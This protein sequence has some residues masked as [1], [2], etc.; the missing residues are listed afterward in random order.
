MLLGAS[1]SDHYFVDERNY[2]LGSGFSEKMGVSATFK[3]KFSVSWQQEGF[4]IFTT[5]GYPQD[6]DF[7]GT[8]NKGIDYQGDK[9]N[10]MLNTST[11]KLDVKLYKQLYFSSE[12]SVFSRYTNYKYFKDVHSITFEKQILLTYKF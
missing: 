5:K 4:H 1:L 6:Y 7:S 10:T 9:S 2:N 11:L 12:V 3:D 8:Y